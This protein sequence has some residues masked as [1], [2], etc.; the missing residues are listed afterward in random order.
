[1]I[2]DRVIERCAELGSNVCVGIDPRIDRLPVEIVEKAAEKFGDT[3]RARASAFLEFGKMVVES[4][5][6]VAAVIKPQLAYFETEG[7]AG[8]Q[9]YTELVAFAKER[10]FYVIADAKRGDIGATSSAYAKAFLSKTSMSADFVTVN[11]YL[12]SDCINEFLKI[13][14]EYDKGVF[15]LVKTSN[16]SSKELQDLVEQESGKKIYEL[17]AA[18]VERESAQRVGKYGYS[19][20]GAVVGATYPEEL[21]ELRDILKTSPFL[22]PGY[23]AQGAGAK[24]IAAAFVQGKGAFVNS[25]RGIIYAKE[26]G[27]SAGEAIRKAAIGMRED[28]RTIY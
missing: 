14:D 25:S 15:V 22:V 24:D 12:G 1:M 26:E 23:G 7:A 21:S 9:A 11:P 5:C 16:P 17:I 4:T 13:A 3:E 19:S 2:I 10:G 27:L 20:V 18:Q 28:L 6:G 8:V